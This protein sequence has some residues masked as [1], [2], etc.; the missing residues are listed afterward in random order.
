MIIS[1][2]NIKGGVGKTTTTAVLAH[3]LTNSTYDKKILCIDFSPQGDLSSIL[4][5]T[6]EYTGDESHTISDVLFNDIEVD[7]AIQVLTDNLHLIP[8]DWELVNFNKNAITSYNKDYQK[9]LLK[10]V[11]NSV[12]SVYDF[13]LIDTSTDMGLILDNALIAS[14]G[15]IINSKPSAFRANEHNKIC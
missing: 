14:D 5:N 1:F 7:D 3:L 6:Y 12:E 13:I 2:G 4:L 8:G 11:L 9:S 10:S 15:V